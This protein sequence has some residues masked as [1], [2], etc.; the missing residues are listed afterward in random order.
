MEQLV[1]VWNDYVKL[2]EE[3][4]K[5]TKK[6]KSYI[7][8]AVSVTDGD[9]K[10]HIFDEDYNKLV[11]RAE[12]AI[13]RIAGIESVYYER[14]KSE[15]TDRIGS[16]YHILE[17]AMGVFDALYEDLKAGYLS[18]LQEIL[19]ADL[20]SS[21][22]EQ[23]EYLLSEGFK[24]A[25]AV[26]AGS[27]LEQHIR[28]LCKKNNIELRKQKNED[29]IYRKVSELK[30][31]LA[32]NKIIPSNDINLITSWIQIRNKSAHGEYDYYNQADVKL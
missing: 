30:D 11:T 19:H 32:K 10:P 25:A 20:F 27:T 8:S 29:V 1:V 9:T 26:I 6:S 13:K 21:F 14:F 12:A 3:A 17:D 22:L 15:I 31:E 4:V 16:N 23:A 28:N 18:N 2:K 5:R 24:D 7:S